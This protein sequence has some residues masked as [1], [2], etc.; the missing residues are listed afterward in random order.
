[1]IPMILWTIST[2][3]PSSPVPVLK[4]LS[5]MEPLM[6]RVSYSLQRSR[7]R[8][9]SLLRGSAAIRPI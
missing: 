2:E 8:I 1:M 5:V 7:L 9:I 4:L 3:L 6:N